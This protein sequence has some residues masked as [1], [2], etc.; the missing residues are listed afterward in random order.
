MTNKPRY[1]TTDKKVALAWTYIKKKDDSIAKQAQ[2]RTLDTAKPHCDC[3]RSSD[4]RSLYLVDVGFLRK[5][6]RSVFLRVDPWGRWFTISQLPSRRHTDL[7][8]RKKL[9]FGDDR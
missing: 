2:Q 4:L 1:I 9:D 5:F 3:H 6:A 7:R 8:F